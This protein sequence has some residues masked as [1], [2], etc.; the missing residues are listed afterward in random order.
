MSSRSEPIAVDEAEAARLLEV[1]RARKRRAVDLLIEHLEDRRSGGLE[2]L[3][4]SGPAGSL[5][6]WREGLL[7]GGASVEELTKVKELCKHDPGGGVRGQLERLA[8]YF[9]AVAAGLCH[10]GQRICSRPMSDLNPILIDLAAV[11]SGP[12]SELFL[13]AS[14][15]D[16]PGE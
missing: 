4:A 2:D 16:D 13:R 12:W 14:R 9:T 15:A 11:T 1:C 10:H 7:S 5:G 8:G 6:S 3:L